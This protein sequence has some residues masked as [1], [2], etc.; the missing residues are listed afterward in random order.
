MKDDGQIVFSCSNCGRMLAVSSQN[1]GKL[2]KCPICGT[3]SPIPSRDRALAPGTGKGGVAATNQGA[4]S[5]GAAQ[6]PSLSDFVT[7]VCR[8]CGQEIEA[9]VDMIG[10]EVDCPTC[11]SSLRIPML[12]HTAAKAE[13]GNQEKTSGD[14]SPPPSGV[15]PSAMTIRIDL[16]DLE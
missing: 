16:S 4:E 9:P 10:M 13:S 5:S 6:P 7:F 14:M 1:V 3:E 8:E 2:G 12:S 15:N 11:S